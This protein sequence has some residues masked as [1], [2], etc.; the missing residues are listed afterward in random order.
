MESFN[1]REDA[2]EW[3]LKEVRDHCVDNYRFAAED[4]SEEVAKYIDRQDRGCCGSFDSVVLI[5]N[6]RTMI[7]CNY[8]H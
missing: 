7:G 2:I 1:S 8:G 3:M 4:N 6:V 5:N